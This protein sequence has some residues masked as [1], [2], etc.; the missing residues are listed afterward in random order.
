MSQKGNRFLFFKKYCSDFLGIVACS[1]HLEENNCIICGRNFNVFLWGARV[2]PG[3][4]NTKSQRIK[5]SW[6]TFHFFL[7]GLLL[8]KRGFFLSHRIQYLLLFHFWEEKNT[9]QCKHKKRITWKWRRF[10]FSRKERFLMSRIIIHFTLRWVLK[11]LINSLVFDWI[12]GFLNDS[13]LLF[14]RHVIFT[15]LSYK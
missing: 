4:Y 5:S 7:L 13:V 10:L 8:R 3:R 9:L 15:G 12:S 2:R 6:R 1:V 11:M 14:F